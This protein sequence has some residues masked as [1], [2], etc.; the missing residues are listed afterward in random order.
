M[1]ALLDRSPLRSADLQTPLGFGQTFEAFLATGDFIRRVHAL[2][3]GAGV[4]GHI[5][6]AIRRDDSPP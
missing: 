3:K 1:L 5:Q 4:G 2:G 6:A